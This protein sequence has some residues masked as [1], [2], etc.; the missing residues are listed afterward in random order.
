[1]RQGA[2]TINRYLSTTFLA[3]SSRNYRLFAGGQAVSISGVW[4]QKLAQAWLVLVLTDSSLMLGVTV[5]LQQIPT[6]V[7]TAAGGA[8]ADRFDRRRILIATN[9]CSIVPALALGVLASL[10]RV[11]LWMVMVAALTEG[12]VD[13]LEKPTR[14][15]FVNDIVSPRLLI[16]AVTLN[17]IIQQSGKLIG[18]AFAGFLIG[19][20]GAP[21]AFFANALSFVPVVI[22]LTMIRTSGADERVERRHGSL[23]DTLH[24]VAHRRELAVALSLTAV[25][26]VFGYN[27]Q[28]LIPVTFRDV[29]GGDAK[30]VGYGFASMG[31]GGVLGGLAVASKIRATG[32]FHQLSA[33]AFG[34]ALAVLG[35]APTLWFAYF[36]TLLVGMASVIFAST[37]GAHVQLAADR[38]MRGRMMGLYVMAMAGSSPI[39]GPMMGGIA[40]VTNARVAFLAAA[41][42]IFLACVAAFRYS[43]AGRDDDLSI[44]PAPVA[45]TQF[46]GAARR[47]PGA[48]AMPLGAQLDVARKVAPLHRPE[49]RWRGGGM[50]RGARDHVP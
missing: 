24:Y 31:L 38:E 40:Q 39:G 29:F 34:V 5:A 28:T 26:G 48:P 14:M 21:A 35:L 45:T 27:F 16:N 13:A 37:A 33:M 3:L 36:A 4:M 42:L 17:H 12:L 44:Q 32:R 30:A 15:S 41:G 9:L 23:R 19:T 46:I 22:G 10:D 43:R 20:V 8:M 47:V 7:L 50:R 18:P 6:L 49:T 11:D 2:T 1:M 25:L